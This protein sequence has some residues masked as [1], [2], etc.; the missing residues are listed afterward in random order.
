MKLIVILI[1]IALE[2]LSS[3]WEEYRPFGWF[4][5]LEDWMH[6]RFGNIALWNGSCGVIAVL[7]APLIVVW[8]IFEWLNS[9]GIVF[10]FLGGLV[11]VVLALGPQAL[12][13][14]V[15]SLL[16]ALTVH[17]Q[18]GAEA[19]IRE[20][21]TDDERAAPTLG[22]AVKGIL[23]QANDR[24]FGV[25]TWFVILGP[26]G[27]ALYRLAVELD[28]TAASRNPQF[29][30]AA[31]EFHALLAWL[32]VRLL[33]LGFALSGSLIHAFERW[34]FDD[35]LDKG[36][37]DDVLINAGLGALL[38]DDPDSFCEEATGNAVLLVGAIKSLIGRTLLV[39]LSVLALMTL[40]GW[41]A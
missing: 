33:A 39:G 34:R 37:N 14:R 35:T 32:P 19:L 6:A 16:T 27:A 11:L 36:H 8:L 3:R 25:L 5:A 10:A 12:S 20:L 28:R 29:S 24:V 26:V 21:A 13:A 9:V 40:A 23:I 15:E 38:I 18:T 22:D 17:D 2:H 1:A 41:A 31:A 7:A 4:Q 30:Q